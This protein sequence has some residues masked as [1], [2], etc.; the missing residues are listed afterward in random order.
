MLVITEEQEHL[1]DERDKL[2]KRLQEAEAIYRSVLKD[3]P[4]HPDAL[5]LLGCIAR[6]TGKN[7]I[8]VNLIEKAIKLNPKAS[9][10]YN[11]CGIARQR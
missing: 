3:Q 4:Q 9:N 6:Q 5:H 10:F 8:A 1:R 7:D 11:S 2:A